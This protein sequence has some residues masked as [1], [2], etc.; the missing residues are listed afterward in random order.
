MCFQSGYTSFFWEVHLILHPYSWLGETS[1]ICFQKLNLR[2]L[3]AFWLN[4]SI[5]MSCSINSMKIS[6]IWCVHRASFMSTWPSCTCTIYLRNTFRRYTRQR[7]G[8]PLYPR[9]LYRL[10]GRNLLTLAFGKLYRLA[11]GDTRASF[12]GFSWVYVTCTRC[13]KLWHMRRDYPEP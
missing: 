4:R 3:Y 13:T 7:N 1:R 11:G 12:T 10:R 6:I 9:V 5:L 2:L 8:Y